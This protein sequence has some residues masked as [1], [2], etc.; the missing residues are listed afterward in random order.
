[1][2]FMAIA[3]IFPVAAAS[4]MSRGLV[5]SSAVVAAV[6]GYLLANKAGLVGAYLPVISGLTLGAYAGLGVAYVERTERLALAFA[7]EQVAAALLGR[8][9]SPS[10]AQRIVQ[11]G[12]NDRSGDVREVTIVFV[13]LRGF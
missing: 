8:H 11:S 4:S 6:F 5:W 12:S 13:D 9:F 7:G 10:V 3:G 2:G 1:M